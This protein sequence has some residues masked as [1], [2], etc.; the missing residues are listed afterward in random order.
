[1]I[2]YIRYTI[3]ILCIVFILQSCSREDTWDVNDLSGKILWSATDDKGNRSIYSVDTTKNLEQ[4][5]I[6]L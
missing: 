4:P 6:Y 2:N 3:Y 5:E 1:M